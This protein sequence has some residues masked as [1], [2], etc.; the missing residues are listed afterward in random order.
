MATTTIGTTTYVYRVWYIVL[1]AETNTPVHTGSMDLE[2]DFMIF[3]SEDYKKVI[4]LIE[5]KHKLL[6]NEKILIRSTKLMYTK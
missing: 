6:K 2:L 3:S 5:K 1:L 4:K